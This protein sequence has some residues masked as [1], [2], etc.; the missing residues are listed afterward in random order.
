[1]KPEEEKSDFPF[2]LVLYR[3]IFGRFFTFL[4]RINH[5]IEI[6]L[7]EVSDVRPIEYWLQQIAAYRFSQS[8]LPVF[9]DFISPF[10]V[11]NRSGY[12]SLGLSMMSMA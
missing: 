4:E 2:P 1:M 11:A 7:I 5:H 12:S 3:D 9:K 8:Q 10:L 6:G